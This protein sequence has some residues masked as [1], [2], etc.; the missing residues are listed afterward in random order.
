MLFLLFSC[1]VVCYIFFLE[2]FLHSQCYPHYPLEEL[3]S[4]CQ[5]DLSQLNKSRRPIK[6][7][8]VV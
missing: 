5:Q 1:F 6:M 7:E 8:Q 4:A 2:Y 3:I